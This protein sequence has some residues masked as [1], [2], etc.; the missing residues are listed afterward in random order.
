MV[1]HNPTGLK[2]GMVA[3]R[4]SICLSGQGQRGNRTFYLPGC[5]S[6]IPCVT[7]DNIPFDIFPGYR[8]MASFRCCQMRAAHA[9]GCKVGRYRGDLN[10]FQD[11]IEIVSLNSCLNYPLPPCCWHQPYPSQFILFFNLFKPSQRFCRKTCGC[12]RFVLEIFSPV[13]LRMKC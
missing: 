8:V 11:D 5:S 4:R 12:F 1:N 3:G 6:L 2:F 9:A 10:V 7:I 13:Q